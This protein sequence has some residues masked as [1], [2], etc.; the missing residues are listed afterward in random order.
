[1]NGDGS[2]PRETQEAVRFADVTVNGQTTLDFTYQVQRKGERPTASWSTPITVDGSPGFMLS[3]VATRD[4]Y[5]V[6]I[7]VAA[8]GGQQ[9]VIEA[10]EIERT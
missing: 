9:I 3:P 10:G 4:T 2:Y 5:I 7:R 8:Q 1:M 6:W